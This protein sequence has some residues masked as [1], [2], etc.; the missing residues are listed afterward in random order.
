MVDAAR[1]EGATFLL[2]K[3][4]VWGIADDEGKSLFESHPAHPLTFGCPRLLEGTTPPRLRC[5]TQRFLNALD[6]F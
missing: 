6:A 3:L 4:A 2:Q 5:T 1:P